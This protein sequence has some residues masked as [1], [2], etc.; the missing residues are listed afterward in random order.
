MWDE[1]GEIRFVGDL[2]TVDLSVDGTHIIGGDIVSHNSTIASCISAY[3][4][5]KLVKRDDPCA[6]YGLLP[7]SEIAI[8]N[9]AP[10]DEQSAIIYNNIVNYT[11]NCPY[12]R[13]RILNKTMGYMKLQSDADRRT[14]EKVGNIY[15]LTGGC[16][17]N[18]VR[19]HSAIIVIKIYFEGSVEA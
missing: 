7:S 19:G 3:E 4:L 1:I 14:G 2:E 11:S 16:S 5:Y 17:A 10:T 12:L 6:Y 8:I 13:D 9:V 15:C 18:G